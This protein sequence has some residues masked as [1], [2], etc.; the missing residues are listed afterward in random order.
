MF[1]LEMDA[2]DDEVVDQ[3]LCIS[4]LLIEDYYLKYICKQPSMN[5]MQIRNMWLK[6]VLEGNDNRCHKMFRT[7]K[8]V[9]FKLYANLEIDYG[10]KGSRRMGAGEILECFCILWDMG[11]ETS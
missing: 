2:S 5:S 6:E 4:A 10:L 3:I 9:F 8:A 11:S 1:I 7:E